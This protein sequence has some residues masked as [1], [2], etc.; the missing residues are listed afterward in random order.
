[1]ASYKRL[2][3]KERRDISKCLKEGKSQ[4]EIAERLGRSRS[5]ISSE[6]RR[7]GMTRE[8]YRVSIAQR[9][10]EVLSEQRVKKRKITGALEKVVIDCLLDHWSPR[11][12]AGYLKRHYSSLEE[13][14]ISPESIYRFVYR[15]SRRRMLIMKLRKKRLRRRKRGEKKLKRGGIK[16]AVS[17]KVRPQEVENREEAGHWE[18]DLI[19]GKNGKSAMGTLVER[20]SRFVMVVQMKSKETEHV[21]KEFS[22]VLGQLPSHMRKSLTYDRGTEMAG[23]EKLTLD[24]EMAVYFADPHSPWQRGSNENMNGLL[25]EFFPKGSDLGSVSAEEVRR[26]EGLLNGRPKEV[27]LFEKPER[28]F[29]LLRSRPGATLE[30]VLEDLLMATVA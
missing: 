8:T 30:E 7:C 21:V 15:H 24:T 20:S 27:L 14:Q 9:N 29:E 5:T 2:S 23:H 11:Q 17:I 6:V 4:A 3:V 22:Q 16:N 28:V 18:G 1:M 19:I 26:V 10:A 25:R 12:I 13:M